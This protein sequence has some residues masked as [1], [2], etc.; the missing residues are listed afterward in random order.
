VGIAY[1]RIHCDIVSE[2][3]IVVGHVSQSRPGLLCDSPTNNQILLLWM[4]AGMVG[5][6][7]LAPQESPPVTASDGCGMKPGGTVGCS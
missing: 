2:A 5:S 1:A 3:P 7:A 4:Q 6:G